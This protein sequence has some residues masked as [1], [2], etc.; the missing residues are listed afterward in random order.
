M[1]GIVFVGPCDFNTGVL[2][3]TLGFLEM[4]LVEVLNVCR[5]LLA[6]NLV[7]PCAANR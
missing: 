5:C 1:S 6:R 2:F 7:N 4:V 3:A